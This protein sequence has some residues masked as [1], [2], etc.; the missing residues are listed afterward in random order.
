MAGASVGLII[1]FT[2]SLAAQLLGTAMLPL[3][4][5]LTR[6]VPTLIGA[7]GFLIGTGL[8]ARLVNSG[9]NLSVLIPLNSTAVPLASIAM[10]FLLVGDTPS[11][12]K[13]AVL[14]AACGLIG[15]AS[16]L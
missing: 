7:L 15:V 3:T 12:P 14:L 5:G 4:Q 13:L 16:K 9:V 6:P 8:M 10:G 11:G 1:T 2:I